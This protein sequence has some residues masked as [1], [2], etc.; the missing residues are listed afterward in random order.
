[1]HD[2]WRTYRDSDWGYESAPDGRGEV[3]PLYRGKVLGGSAWMTRFVM[4]GSP[5]DFDGWVRAGNPGW[6][7][8]DTLD[9][10]RRLEHDLDF[11]G[12]AWHGDAGPIPVTRY[13]G[14]DPSPYESAVAEAC[15]AAGIPLVDDHNRPGA[16]GAGRMPRNAR[17]GLRVTSV[18]GYLPTDGSLPDT[19]EIRPEAQVSSILVEDDR[20]VGVRM[21]DGTDV[22]A[23]W[24]VLCA[25]TYGSPTLLLRS[26]IGPPDHLRDVGVQVLVPL[27]G[28]GEN[29]ADHQGFDVDAGYRGAPGTGP[30]F[31]W[32]ATFRGAT[33]DE[34]EPLDL[35]LWIP[36]PFGI[37]DQPTAADVTAVLLTP[38]SRGTVRLR[39]ADPSAAPVITL[40]GLTDPSDVERLAEAAVVAKD[41]ADHHAVRHLCDD[42]SGV[43]PPAGKALNEVVAREAWSYPHT[44]G[45]CAMGPSPDAG[46]VVDA[47]GDVHG[48]SR[49]SIA[50]A[51][52]IPTA[53]SGFP[54]V[55]AL[56]IAERMAERYDD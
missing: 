41:V 29:L 1:M 21:L 24:V 36:E 56:M 31:F 44:V 20:A 42:P 27:P 48:L 46:A 10:F 55:I 19:L 34:D 37:G 53:P 43:L 47:R 12:E 49:L 16:L 7:F 26:G 3:E 14:I 11:A 54:H 32:L 52:V 22:E 28:V 40:P 50:D 9:A 18:D 23:G 8:A 2:G 6:G 4:R 13:P 15:A 25:G 33:A 5:E 39:S 38:R 35:G 45:T 51:S 30:R 17:A